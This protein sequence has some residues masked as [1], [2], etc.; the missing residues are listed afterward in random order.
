[1]SEEMPQNVESQEEILTF[2]QRIERIDHLGNK[3][4]SAVLQ[5]V[6]SRWLQRNP[7]PIYQEDEDDPEPVFRSALDDNTSRFKQAI[8]FI[9]PTVIVLSFALSAAKQMASN[10]LILSNVVEDINLKHILMLFMLGLTESSAL[11]FMMS[12]ADHH[13]MAKWV[14]RTF[15][16]VS[17]GMAILGNLS[18]STLYPIAATLWSVPWF[19]EAAW[20]VVPP[21][22]VIGC[23]YLYELNYL[24]QRDARRNEKRQFESQREE[25][26]RRRHERRIAFRAAHSVWEQRKV[27]YNNDHK[28]RTAILPQQ[29][30][31][32]LLHFHLNSDY[33]AR[34]AS[35]YPQ[36]SA[37]EIE[38]LLVEKEIAR[39]DFGFE[40]H[41]KPIQIE[42]A[43]RPGVPAPTGGS[44][45]KE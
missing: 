41:D 7:E 35:D 17:G 26:T 37:V 23:G 31:E 34:I 24:S 27:E 44:H 39:H 33:V 36:M 8:G 15:S 19:L 40:F 30:R 28:V 1:M 38:R 43:P 45:Q 4:W 6:V 3:E 42:S 18:T 21:C 32:S 10:D 5:G 22:L 11:G 9:L 14:L 12:S 16:F 25:W 29:V 20:T 13:K 2:D